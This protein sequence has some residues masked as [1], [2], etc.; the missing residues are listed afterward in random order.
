MCESKRWTLF[1]LSLSPSL[2]SFS[3][4]LLP[5]SFPLLSPLFFFLT[6]RA[7][8]AVVCKEA[9]LKLEAMCSQS[10]GKVTELVSD[11]QSV[12][13]QTS[14]PEYLHEELNTDTVGLNLTVGN[15]GPAVL[16]AHEL[17]LKDRTFNS[18][19]FL[20][21]PPPPPSPGPGMSTC[22]GKG[23]WQQHT[24]GASSLSLECEAVFPLHGPAEKVKGGENPPA[25]SMSDPLCA[26]NVNGKEPSKHIASEPPPS[27]PASEPPPPFC[28]PGPAS[29]PPPPFFL[30][31]PAQTTMSPTNNTGD[32]DSKSS[33]PTDNITSVP[34]EA[35]PTAP[36][37]LLP[38]HTQPTTLPGYPPQYYPMQTQPP[39]VQSQPIIVTQVLF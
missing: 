10:N 26:S 16:P 24:A 13:L 1:T 29:E 11:T 14:T 9:V 17:P 20:Y 35:L 8:P 12:P 34:C 22:Q 30:P 19:S 31:G 32:P 6:D 5:P 33:A 21:P 18:Q 39:A 15:S 4:P 2:G 28:L 25:L 38:S 27:G 36:P 37:T 23:V 7:E 3:L